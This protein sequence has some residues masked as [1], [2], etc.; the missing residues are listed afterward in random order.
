MGDNDGSAMSMLRKI[1]AEMVQHW[2]ELER[3][4]PP[5]T[6]RHALNAKLRANVENVLR[7]DDDAEAMIRSGRKPSQAHIDDMKRQLKE[8]S[9]QLKNVVAFTS[10]LEGDKFTKPDG[11]DDL[12]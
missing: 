5:G 2:P 6:P 4:N 9:Y 11:L 7:L 12:P 10:E 3:S 1:H 8:V